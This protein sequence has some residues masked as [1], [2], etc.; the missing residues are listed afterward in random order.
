MTGAERRHGD[1]GSEKD[2]QQQRTTQQMILI[3][4]LFSIFIYKTTKSKNENSIKDK[5]DDNTKDMYNGRRKNEEF[6]KRKMYYILLTFFILNYVISQ[7]IILTFSLFL[8]LSQK[9]YIKRERKE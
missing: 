8:V 6:E 7:K 2:I 5:I 3:C 9:E 1:K 4:D